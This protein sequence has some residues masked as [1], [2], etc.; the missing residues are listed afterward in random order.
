MPYQEYETEISRE[1]LNAIFSQMQEPVCLLGGWAVYIT[2]NTEFSNR[3]GRNYLGSKDIDLGFHIDPKWSLEELKNSALAQSVK[4]LDDRKFIGIGS[5]FVKNYDIV[6]REEITEEESK[7]RNMYDM[8]QLFVDP[9]AD[10]QHAETQKIVGFA[11][12]D[13]PLLSRVFVDGNYTI[14][15]EFGGKFKLPMPETLIS[16]K[17]KSV[18]IRTQDDKRIKDISDIYA[19]L[20]Y[21]GVDFHEMKQRV[22]QT[23]KSQTITKAA[24][25]FTKEEYDKVSNAIGI[26]PEEISRVINELT[27]EI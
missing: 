9:M 2:V 10:N 24:S 27:K 20:W 3:N 12:L 25:G 5:R 13:E 15:T 16:T 7:K 4:I 6:T 8:F 18:P 19:L 11:L 23:I 21:S 22:R 17:L 26:P 14:L 1:H